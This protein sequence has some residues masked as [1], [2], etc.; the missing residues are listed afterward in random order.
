MILHQRHAAGVTHLTHAPFL[1]VRVNS[2]IHALIVQDCVLLHNLDIIGFDTYY[3]W[4]GS[5]AGIGGNLR[6]HDLVSSDTIALF[7][8]RLTVVVSTLRHSATTQLNR[9]G[10]VGVGV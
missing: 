7:C 9:Y 1:T 2:P 5:A 3:L 6:R 10:P 4:R 8:Q